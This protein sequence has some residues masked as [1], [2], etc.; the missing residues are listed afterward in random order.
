[1]LQA[2]LIQIF[3]QIRPDIVWTTLT[4]SIS[5][6]PSFSGIESIIIIT[7]LLHLRCIRSRTMTPT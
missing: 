7:L 1:M 5:K 2:I 3:I 6:F 4:S